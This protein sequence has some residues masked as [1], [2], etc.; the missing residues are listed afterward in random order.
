[1]YIDEKF[2]SI[3]DTLTHAAAEADGGNTG[4]ALAAIKAA[5][6]EIDDLWEEIS[7]SDAPG[8]PRDDSEE[9]AELAE[10]L[11]NSEES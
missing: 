9:L 4:G 10:D 5:R 11:M 2:Q 1:M 8:Y 7:P 3:I 6:N